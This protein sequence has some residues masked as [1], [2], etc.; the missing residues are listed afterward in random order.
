VP[1][2]RTIEHTGVVAPKRVPRLEPPPTANDP[3]SGVLNGGGTFAVRVVAIEQ[4]PALVEA[5]R[6]GRGVFL[7]T[8]YMQDADRPIL[9]RLDQHFRSV[10]RAQGL[11]Q[12]EPL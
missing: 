12:L 8:S 9:K 2:D 5:A 6:R 1:L 10:P 3:Y 7:D 11:Y 4:L